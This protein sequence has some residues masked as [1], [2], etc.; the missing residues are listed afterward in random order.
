MERAASLLCVVLL[1]VSLFTSG[2][3]T[4]LGPS[5]VAAP[6]GPS[7]VAAPLGPSDGAAVIPTVA[8]ASPLVSKGG[9]AIVKYVVKLR[10]TKVNG[11]V[12]GDIGAWGKAVAKA[13]RY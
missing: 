2:T 4:P 7:D 11:K 5:D 6:L 3:A 12:I 10:P 13:I 9:K 8:Q 1:C